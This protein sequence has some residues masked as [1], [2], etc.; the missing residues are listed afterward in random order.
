MILEATCKNCKVEYTYNPS[1]RQGKYCST[2]CQNRYQSRLKVE[3]GNAGHVACRRYLLEHVGNSCVICSN[4][5]QWLGNPLTLHMDHID[6]DRKNNNLHNLRLLCPNC[7][8]Q[9]DTWGFNNASE[10]EKARQ[11]EGCAR[12]WKSKKQT[13]Q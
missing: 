1:Y 3:A 10:V 8:H 6:G 7:H 11:R 5:G 9:T 4:P 12:Y 13:P 2:K